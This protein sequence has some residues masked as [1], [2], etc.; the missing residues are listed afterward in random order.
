VPS[1]ERGAVAQVND[2][3]TGV[4]APPQFG[5]VNWLG[6]AEVDGIGATAVQ[7]PHVGVVGGVGP[8]PGEQRVDVVLLGQG[9]RRVD[10]LLSADGGGIP[11]GR[12]GRA[13][14]AEPVS[15]ED[16]SVSGQLAG[17][18]AHRVEL[19]VGQLLGVLRP[20][21]VG[22]AGGAVEHGSAGE[23]SVHPPVGGFQGVADVVVG[24]PGGVQ[25]AQPHPAG[26]DHVA[27]ADGVVVE[28]QVIA[29]GE[30]IRR[31]GAPGQLKPA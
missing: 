19:G 29:R 15:R 24:V 3:L 7:W 30:N 18:P 26:F 1:G 13:E 22:A 23:D 11:A 9:Q 20:D 8:Q 25:H 6:R 28:P 16:R 12:G 21:Q 5:R 2:P 10:L 27:V 14:A 31:A 17:Q 4:D